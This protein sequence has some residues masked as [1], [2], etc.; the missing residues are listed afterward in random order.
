LILIQKGRGG[1]LASAFGG[2]GGNTA[3]GSKTG[4]VLTWATSI[5]FGVF[6]LLAV[7]LNLMTRPGT[8]TTTAGDLPPLQ[9][10]QAPVQQPSRQPTPPAPRDTPPVPAP[11]VLPSSP[12]TAPI[13]APST[14]PAA[15]Q[16][17]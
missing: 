11:N 10:Q 14:Q 3:F 4:D 16:P 7:I 15:S 8:K 6:L 1:G 13:K 9:G 12:A 2:G 5:I 17:K